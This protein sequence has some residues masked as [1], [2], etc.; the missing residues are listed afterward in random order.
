[1]NTSPSMDS[2]ATPTAPADGP[3]TAAG[4]L[5]VLKAAASALKRTCEKREFKTWLIPEG[6]RLLICKGYFL[7]RNVLY[8]ECDRPAS[9][10]AEHLAILELLLV[11][12]YLNLLDRFFAI[13]RR[14][15]AG[16]EYMIAR[17]EAG[18]RDD[19]LCLLCGRSGLNGCGIESHHIVTLGAGG[20]KC[21]VDNI[22]SLC[23]RDHKRITHPASPE[24][25]W[26]AIAP[27]LFAAAGVSPE[28]AARLLAEAR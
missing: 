7:A 21:D 5:R 27:R 25:H 8:V 20:P 15:G 1:M 12:G 9:A 23:G 26:K 10:K 2:S 16:G 18:Q 28:K 14:I 13:A 3:S 11:E 4:T 22:A 24:W 6:L 17:W 19:F